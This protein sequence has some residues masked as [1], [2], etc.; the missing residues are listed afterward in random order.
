MNS[1]RHIRFRSLL[2]AL[3]A[4][5]TALVLAGAVSAAAD[6]SASPSTAAGIK[7]TLTAEP[8]ADHVDLSWSYVGKPSGKLRYQVIRDG[9]VLGTSK[10]A[11]YQDEDVE[12][13]ATYV[14]RVKATSSAARSRPA[15]SNKV[16]VTIPGDVPPQDPGTDDGP[17]PVQPLTALTADHSDDLGD[18]RFMATNVRISRNEGRIDGTTRTRTTNF[19]VG[20]HGAVAVRYLNTNGDT[21][22]ISTAQRYGVDGLV[23]AFNPHDITMSWS[24]EIPP[25]V[26]KRIASVEIIHTVSP[27]P[28]LIGILQRIRDTACSVWQFFESC[29]LPQV[30]VHENP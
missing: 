18:G 23:V 5:S 7:L 8:S 6:R 28:D 10:A 15:L 26:A 13:D 20:Y 29:P 19:W 16:T 24:D 9:E 22:G 21:I 17:G 30:A 2:L 25:Q 11:K 4:A 12:Q 3:A 14:Y 1:S 27:K